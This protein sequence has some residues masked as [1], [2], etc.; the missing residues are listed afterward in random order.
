MYGS[1]KT[2]KKPYRVTLRRRPRP[3]LP[4]PG[5]WGVGDEDGGGDDGDVGVY[6]DGG[7]RKRAESR[8]GRRVKKNTNLK[9]AL[10]GGRARASDE[11]G[12]VASASVAPAKPV[13]DHAAAI[14]SLA[15]A[16][17]HQVRCKRGRIASYSRAVF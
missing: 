6:F 15:E 4:P 10:L 7:K 11:G 5:D 8:K 3:V 9:E 2:L 14:K 13:R 12:R 1:S 17:K 16:H